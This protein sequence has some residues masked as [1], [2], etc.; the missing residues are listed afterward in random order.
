MR[1]NRIVLLLILL[2]LLIGC[3][4]IPKPSSYCGEIDDIC[5]EEI[6]NICNLISG[7]ICPDYG[8]FLVI[9]T[10]TEINEWV[11]L[12]NNTFDTL[13]KAENFVKSEMSKEYSDNVNFLIVK[14]IKSY[15][16]LMKD[17]KR[18]R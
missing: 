6:L 16:E 17:D 2:I 10:N 5:P 3:K 15:E 7:D 12:E 18:R 9:E 8:K 11:H 4:P 13:E 1:I 14:Q